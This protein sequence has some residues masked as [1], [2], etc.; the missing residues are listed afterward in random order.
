LRLAVISWG[1]RQFRHIVGTGGN[2]VSDTPP[3]GLAGITIALTAAAAA[4]RLPCGKMA[5]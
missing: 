2:R 4:L 3:A 5:D 1:G